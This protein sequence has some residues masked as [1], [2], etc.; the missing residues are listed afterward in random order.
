[1]Q[2]L[3]ADDDAVTRRIVGLLLNRL[4]H[5]VLEAGD[6]DQALALFAAHRPDVII[7]DWEM[8]GTKG[9]ELVDKVRAMDGADDYTYFIL[10]TS[11]DDREAIAAS[12]AA[13]VDDHL[14]K[15]LDH[16]QLTRRMAVA[17]R[18]TSLQKRLTAANQRMRED[19]LAAQRA[20]RALLP[21]PLEVIPGL[22]CATRLRPCDELA[23]DLVG[24]SLLD[25]DHLGLH[26]VDI[27]GHGVAAALLAVQ[28]AR[29]LTPV[30]GTG[31][32][33]CDA[34]G[35]VEATEVPRLLNGIFQHGPSLQFMTMAYGLLD[36]RDFRLRLAMS[37]H[38]APIL[39]RRDGTTE[40]VEVSS[41]P[42]GLFPSNRLTITTWET[43]LRPGDQVLLFSD[44]ATEAERATEGERATEAESIGGEFG[45]ERLV[46]A[47]RRFADV[48]V[49][50]ALDGILTELLAWTGGPL[51]DDASL[52]L[53]RRS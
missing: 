33:L 24:A 35:P 37:A 14:G 32:V 38:P 43:V 11:H 49:D 12:S 13:G 45:R 22:T 3:V 34:S 21:P 52:L 30:A 48:T 16:H 4:G 41:Q 51:R 29:Y 5:T 6:G 10:L 44:G 39:L 1:M 28:V 40:E 9:L 18:L 46:A 26:V 25:P 53:L 8:P 36:L 27:S 7:A 19:L 50:E 20:Q 2:V 23:G 47:L 17:A 15:P 31:S 42:L